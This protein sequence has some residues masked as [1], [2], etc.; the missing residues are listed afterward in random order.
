MI[1]QREDAVGGR[2]ARRVVAG[3][4]EQPEEDEDLGVVEALPVDLGVAQ[5][6]DKRV[7]IALLDLAG[8][9]LVE[10]DRHLHHDVHRRCRLGRSLRGLDLLGPSIQ[11]RDVLVRESHEPREHAE[12]DRDGDVLDGVELALRDR[13]VDHARDARADVA[14]ELADRV[15]H[16]R[17]L[18]DPAVLRVLGRVLEQQQVAV[19][20]ERVDLI[21]MQ[22]DP[23]PVGAERLRVAAD[24]R[25]LGVARERPEAAAAGGVPADRRLGAHAGE[26]LVRRAFPEQHR[27]HQVDLR[28]IHIRHY[29]KSVRRLLASKAWRIQRSN[30]IPP[31]ASTSRPATLAFFSTAT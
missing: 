11:P 3:E 13:G 19:H 9:L 17:A 23:G 6:H 12:R 30:Q 24:L 29:V 25:D 16:E 28:Q 8:D 27:I 15:G 2:V 22:E 20:V 10:V 7:V 1:E 5:P 21:G 31:T 18:Q 4:D 14:L 26:E